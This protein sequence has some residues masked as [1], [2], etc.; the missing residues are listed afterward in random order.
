ML[1]EGV[2]DIPARHVDV[3]QMRTIVADAIR[4]GAFGAST[5]WSIR[6]PQPGG[7]GAAT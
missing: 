5:S 2:E 4:A 3:E 7:A 6:V 1:M